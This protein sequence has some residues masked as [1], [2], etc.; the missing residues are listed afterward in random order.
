MDKC[1]GNITAQR[2]AAGLGPTRARSTV[3][4][5]SHSFGSGVR[6][7]AFSRVDGHR[8]IRLIASDHASSGSDPP[9]PCRSEMSLSLSD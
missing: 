9:T 5:A 8:G 4:Y 1:N 2:A 6:S 7:A 3:R